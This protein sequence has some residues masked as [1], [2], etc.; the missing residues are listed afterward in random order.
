MSEV[1]HL[2]RETDVSVVHYS[3]EAWEM[4]QDMAA[5]EAEK[6]LPKLPLSLPLSETEAQTDARGISTVR[7][8]PT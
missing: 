2:H 1:Y 8:I 3:K 6:D 7:S 4:T 5:R